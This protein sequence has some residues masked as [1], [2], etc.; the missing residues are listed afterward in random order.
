[1][2]NED[3]IR[4]MSDQLVAG[5]NGPLHM[6]TLAGPSDATK[7][8]YELANGSFYLKTDTNPLSVVHF[9]EVTGKWSDE[10]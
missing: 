2:A 4:V 10:V 6:M 7:P 8:T 3:K 1:M 5:P 9:N